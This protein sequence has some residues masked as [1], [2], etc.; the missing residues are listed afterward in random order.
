MI[1]FPL[2]GRRDLDPT[3]RQ[4]RHQCCSGGFSLK[5]ELGNQG[6]ILTTI[7]KLPSSRLIGSAPS[8]RAPIEEYTHL[9]ASDRTNPSYGNTNSSSTT[10]RF[11]GHAG[12]E[13]QQCAAGR[14]RLRR[15]RCYGHHHFRRSTAQ[16]EKSP[17]KHIPTRPATAG[18]ERLTNSPAPFSPSRTEP[19]P[20]APTAAATAASRGRG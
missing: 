3:S 2:Q 17:R 14:S 11:S 18:E 5:K 1:S 20:A 12:T 4:Q 7:P 10:G 19:K 15:G 6:S 16:I 9:S 8:L 13:D